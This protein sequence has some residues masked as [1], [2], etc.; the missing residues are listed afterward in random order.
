MKAY[1]VVVH[2]I[3]SNHR[4]KLRAP[5]RQCTKLRLVP[6]K[7]HRRLTDV[8][9]ELI[10]IFPPC[11]SI[12]FSTMTHSQLIGSDMSELKAK[13]IGAGKVVRCLTMALYHNPVTLV[14]IIYNAGPEFA[15]GIFATSSALSS[16]VVNRA[17]LLKSPSIF[18]TVAINDQEL[19]Q[20]I[21]N[22]IRRISSV[23][24]G[25]RG[26][27]KFHETCKLSFIQRPRVGLF[28][29]LF[30]GSFMPMVVWNKAVDIPAR[31]AMSSLVIT[32]ISAAVGVS[33]GDVS[34]GLETGQH[35]PDDKFAVVLTFP[36]L[37]RSFIT[38]HPKVQLFSR[39]F[40]TTTYPRSAFRLIPIS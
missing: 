4:P 39:S 23:C 8:D 6:Q 34:W 36:R 19:L 17:L 37:N 26:L 15:H 18:S 5:H 40:R 12:T 33:S 35:A 20:K 21:A 32:C 31:L 25:R 27:C 24:E 10:R 22:Q 11:Y 9:I 14:A 38:F 7:S 28:L 13:T 3:V 16:F 1:Y 30:L 29:V 2:A